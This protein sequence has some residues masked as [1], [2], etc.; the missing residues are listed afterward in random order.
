[1][2]LTVVRSGGFAGLAARGELDP[3]AEQDPDP[4]VV[5]LLDRVLVHD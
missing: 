2:I 3:T 5:R 4:A 1:V